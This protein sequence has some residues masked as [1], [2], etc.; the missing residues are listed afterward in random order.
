MNNNPNLNLLQRYIY[1]L[2]A[3]IL[4]LSASVV[5]YLYWEIQ[6]TRN[7]ESVL[8][9]FHGTTIFLSSRIKE[10][11][12]LLDGEFNRL[13]QT[14]R[15]KNGQIA[16]IFNLEPHFHSISKSLQAIFELQATFKNPEFESILKRLQIQFDRFQ[17]IAKNETLD[18]ETTF[19]SI[20][21]KSSSF[22][23]PLSQLMRLHLSEQK[24]LMVK[25]SA[26]KRRYATNTIVILGVILLFGGIVVVKILSAI[27][28]ILEKEIISEKTLKRTHA[29]LERS[30]QD[31][32][33]FASIASHDLKEPLRKVITFSDRL[34]ET[35]SHTLDEKGKNYLNRMQKSVTRMATFIDDLLR[36]S[37]VS[38]KVHAFEPTDMG[39]VM[40]NVLSNLEA[41]INQTNGQVKIDS[42]PIIHAD[43]FQMHQLFQNLVSNAFKFHKE[44]ETPIVHVK[45]RSLQNGFLE[46]MVEDNGI[47][48]KEQYLDRIFKPFERLNG[49]SAYEG[50]GMG[51]A[52]C[53]KIVNK[54]GGRLTAKS[55]LQV[56]TTFIVTLPEKQQKNN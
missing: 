26:E 1:L 9:Q 18:K 50:S 22:L 35:N 32:N 11:L 10:E 28:R 54:H 40:K 56:G 17:A 27:Q 44:G 31:L 55:A 37:Q 52:I 14:R 13:Q 41:R 51:L 25:L 42:L 49:A 47:G 24:K 38:Q 4:I 15:G 30:N 46:I 7:T 43:E 6:K 23:I 20:K 34:L 45:C 2:V 29:E 33:D 16:Y 8:N 36:Y 53:R 19:R 5:G 39:K 48:F 21:N 3:I 12:V